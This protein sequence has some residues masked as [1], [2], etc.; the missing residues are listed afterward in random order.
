MNGIDDKYIE[1]AIS[2]KVSDTKAAHIKRRF[3][4]PLIAAIILILF[5]GS[6]AAIVLISKGDLWIQSPSGDPVESV[7]AALENQVGKNYTVKLRIESIELDEAET[8]RTIK[9]YLDTPIASRNN[10]S[11]AY[12]NEHFAAVKSVYY[13]EYDHTE[14]TRSDGEV[15]MYFYLVQNIDSG[16]WTIVDN[17]G[18]I[19]QTKTDI[20]E[21]SDNPNVKNIKEQLFSYLSE[22]FTDA[23]SPYYDG[24]R[25][26][27]SGYSET[28]E[29]N[30]VTATF[31]WTMYHL[32]K[33]WDVPTDEGVEQQ[34]NW[35]LQVTADID[36]M[37]MLKTETIS[38]LADTSA[39]GESDYR[40][41]IS[42]YFPD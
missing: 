31:I 28:V 38:V 40:T 1:K 8:V 11:E 23:Y 14:T 26:E 34:A 25:Y 6:V 5:I 24:L 35:P 29:N 16:K 36:E 15:T 13:A 20:E 27:M 12:L 37:N 4:M 18:N 22:L 2:Y 3:S 33:A 7:R 39:V 10:W 9:R 30:K 19:S 32:G 41:P 42:E 21:K 17:S